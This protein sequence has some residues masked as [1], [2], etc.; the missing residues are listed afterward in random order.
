MS[1]QNI[2]SRFKEG[3]QDLVTIDAAMNNLKKMLKKLMQ[4]Q[5]TKE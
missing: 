4:E 1:Q 2:A 3:R 5:D